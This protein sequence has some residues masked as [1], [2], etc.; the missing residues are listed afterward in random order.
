MA[1]AVRCAGRDDVLSIEMK[2]VGKSWLKVL[3]FCFAGCNGVPSIEKKTVGKMGLK[4]VPGLNIAGPDGA[5][6]GRQ[7]QQRVRL[8]TGQPKLGNWYKSK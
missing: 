5:Q 3:H 8:T 4:G 1:L 7:H 2:T 6:N